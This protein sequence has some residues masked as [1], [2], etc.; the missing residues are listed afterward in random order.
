MARAL[1]ASILMTAS[2]GR[3]PAPPPPPPVAEDG[4]EKLGPPKPGEWLHQF[5]EEGQPFEDYVK[6]CANRRSA[7]RSTF[8]IQPLGDARDRHGGTID[9]M[10]DYAERFFAVP[11]KVLPPIPMFE[12]GYVPQRRQ[13]NATMIIGQLAERVPP[14]ALACVAITSEDLFSKGLNFVFGEGSLRD[15]TGVYSLV[16]YRTDDRALFLRRALKLMSHEAGH[17][18][19]IEHCIYYRCVMQGANSLEEDDRHPMHLCPVDLRK[20]QWNTGFEPRERAARLLEFYRAAGLQ[21]EADWTE[22]RL[23]TGS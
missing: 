13:Y 4:F 6:E 14:D 9:L 20:L 18:L 22:R 8:Y 17:I 10:R 12:N 11:A 16:R 19:S 5:R 21:D 2:C 3:T 15:R 7:G 23:R 1:V